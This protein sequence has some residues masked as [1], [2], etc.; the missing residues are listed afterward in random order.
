MKPAL[1][2]LALVLCFSDPTPLD[3]T[4]LAG[5]DYQE[6]QKLPDK[7]TKFDGKTIKIRGFMRPLEDGVGD[8]V[9][10]FYL[11]NQACDCTG[12]PKLNEII[13]CT[14]P[15]GKTADIADDPVTVVGELSV[16]EE[17]DADDY[18]TSIY[19]LKVTAF[20]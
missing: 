19:R 6:G 16:G 1:A 14:L 15:D 3:F 12:M 18:V 8:K 2:A 11:V 4:I 7:V 9:S 17:R 5:F 10:Q 20:N 13:L